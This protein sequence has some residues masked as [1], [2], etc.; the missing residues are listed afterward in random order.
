[1]LL[2]KDSS[3]SIHDRIIQCLAT[4]IYK[5]N[6]RLSPPVVSNSFTQKNCQPY[7]LRLLSF[8]DLLLGLNF[9]GLKVY[10]ILVWLSGTFFLIVTKTYLILVFLK[11]E[12]KNGSLKI[13]TADFAKHTFLELALHR[14]SLR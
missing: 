12:L 6:T 1:M 14:L 11:A 7:N 13:D 5:V 10:F 9:M 4:E 8:S 2:E 3:A